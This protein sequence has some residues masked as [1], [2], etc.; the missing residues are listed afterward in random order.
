M[1][2]QS[3]MLLCGFD[4]A[5]T[6]NL[7]SHLEQHYQVLVA[8]TE[9]QTKTLLKAESCD[10]IVCHHNRTTIDAVRLL[11]G[12]R[13]SHPGVIRILGGDLSQ[14]ELVAAI[15]DA[16]VYQFFTNPWMPEE[17]EL[18]VRRALETRELAY[19]HRHLNRELKIAEDT[20]E[21]QA[22]F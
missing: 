5:G 3:T 1:D 13:V 10:L 21:A 8:A 7:K 6:D 2:H 19:R 17:M 15:N 14:T 12:L 11:Q 20:R 22:F 9:E 18:M 16:A 4:A